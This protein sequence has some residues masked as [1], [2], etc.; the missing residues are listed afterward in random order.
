MLEQVGECR[1]PVPA[2]QRT[3]VPRKAYRNVAVLEPEV[4]FVAGFDT[5]PIAQLLGDDHLP[6]GPDAMSQANKYNF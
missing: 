2:A 3:V 6:L 4:D 1:T 5:E